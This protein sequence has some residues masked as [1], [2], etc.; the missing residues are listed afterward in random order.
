MVNPTIPQTLTVQYDVLGVDG[1]TPSEPFSRDVGDPD[2]VPPNAQQI[3]VINQ[4]AVGLIDPDIGVGGSIGDRFIPWIEVVVDDAA[5]VNLALVDGEDPDTVLEVIEAAGAAAPLAPY[6]RDDVFRVPQGALLR[7]TCDPVDAGV[8]VRL[9]IQS[10][11][12]AC[13]PPDP[14]PGPTGPT[15]ATGATGPTGATGATGPEALLELTLDELQALGTA[16]DPAVGVGTIAFA[17][18]LQ[19][20]VYCQAAVANSSTWGFKQWSTKTPQIASASVSPDLRFASWGST[21]IGTTASTAGC[22]LLCHWPTRIRSM[23]VF[24]PNNPGNVAM[25]VH[26]NGNAVALEAVTEAVPAATT[27]QFDFTVAASLNAGDFMSIGIDP[28]NARTASENQ[29]LSI[30]VEETVTLP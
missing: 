16:T 4:D 10:D 13:P 14:L 22:T 26:Q 5:T 2:F 21:T 23:V 28:Q 6:Y 30:E 11:C 27:T 17:T 7:V 25:S 12:E 8:K 19:T 24:I 9:R 3:Y 1:T 18:D 29:I 20:F 15:G